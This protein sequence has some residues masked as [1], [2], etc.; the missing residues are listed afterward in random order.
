LDIIGE[1]PKWGKEF[2]FILS[3]YE[4]EQ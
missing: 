4:N 3:Y 1:S 2:S